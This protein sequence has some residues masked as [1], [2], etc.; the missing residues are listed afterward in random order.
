MPEN[1]VSI[2][3]VFSRVARRGQVRPRRGGRPCE[4]LNRWVPWI[5]PTTEGDR[6]APLAKPPPLLVVLLDRPVRALRPHGAHG[7]VRGARA[8]AAGLLPERSQLRATAARVRARAGLR[9]PADLRA[10]RERPDGVPDDGAA[11]AGRRVPTAD[12]RLR[13]LVERRLLGLER[14]RLGLVERLLAARASRVHLHR[15]ALRL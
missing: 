5:V 8:A 7:G 4:P 3:S 12:A 1:T 10:R 9:A 13:L 14:L 11:A 2:V 15:P 6:H